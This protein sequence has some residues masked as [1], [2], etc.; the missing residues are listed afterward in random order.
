LRKL[1]NCAVCY[2]YLPIVLFL[3]GWAKWWISIP[4]AAVSGLGI[5]YGMQKINFEDSKE[6]VLKKGELLIFFLLFVLL[7]VFCGGGD[8][9]PQDYDWSKH[10]AILRDL[11]NYR[12]PVVYEEDAMLTYYL[13]QYIV[14]AFVG[15]ICG[16]SMGIAVWTQTIWNALGLLIAFSFVCQIVKADSL[17]KKTG[18]FFLMIFWGGATGFGSKVYQ[19]L[20]HEVTL[21]SFK[22]ID[23]SRVLVHFASN[24]DAL[25]GAFQ[26]LIVPWICCGIFMQNAKRVEI[27][28]MLALPLFFSST[29]GFVY[30]VLLLLGCIV[31]ELIEK[32]DFA[33]IKRVFSK[34]N[35]CQVPILALLVVYYAGNVFGEKVDGMG[36]RFINMLPHWHFFLVFIAVE[37]MG[38]AVF[39]FWNN[40]KNGLYYL[41]VVQLLLIPFVSMG[42]F[43]DLC[44]RGSIPARFLLMV[45]C[46]EQLY[47]KKW[48]Y[49]WNWLL[50]CVLLLAAINT[51][52]E[53][54]EVC[55]LTRVFGLS[56]EEMI[57]DDFGTLNG[58][59]GNP[60]IRVDE[61]YNYYT[62]NYS[63]SMFRYVG[64]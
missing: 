44:S 39:L 34:S 11:V 48:K 30:F 62:L 17:W 59:A 1:Y 22:W 27:Y 52:N 25:R 31:L 13:G 3:F 63:R 49:V 15:K 53:V 5:Y 55:R 54:K 60:Q 50:I 41:V 57:M 26:H 2:L 40:R 38:Y 56:H 32:K 4:V 43:N 19:R 29:F 24:L 21:L 10:H 36:I 16:N 28:A 23:I 14:P 45:W 58:M 47:Q 12:W 7:C 64:R 37:F 51:F 8:L 42:L 35:W 6:V 18:V 61:A 46:I 20:G 33:I 9:F